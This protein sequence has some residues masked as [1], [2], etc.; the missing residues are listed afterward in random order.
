LDLANSVRNTPTIRLILIKAH[1][2][3]AFLPNILSPL[4]SSIVTHKE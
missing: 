3:G 1:L 4:F 2:S